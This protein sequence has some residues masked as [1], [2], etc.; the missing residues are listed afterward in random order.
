MTLAAE[1]RTA[2]EALSP[3]ALEVINESAQHAG[4]AG[5]DGSGE[6]HW[7]IKIAAASLN[8]LTRIARHRAIHDA[9]GPTIIGRIHALAIE[10]K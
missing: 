9:L 2:L 5:D 4:H 3:E 1:I 10:I 6:S 7:R 8:D